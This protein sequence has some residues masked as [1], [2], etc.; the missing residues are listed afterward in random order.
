MGFIEH[1]K[2]LIPALSGLAITVWNGDPQPL[3]EFETCFCFVPE[4]Q[5]LYTEK[6][7]LSFFQKK[8]GGHIYAL[9]DALDTKILVVKID[10]QWIILGPY[11]ISEWQETSAKVL[12]AGYGLGDAFCLPY[13]LYRSKLP[14]LEQGYVIRIAT[15]LLTH[16]A[17]C[18]PPLE[19]ENIYLGP[20]A[21]TETRAHIAEQ[22]DAVELINRRYFTENQLIEAIAQGK[23]AEALQLNREM[24]LLSKGL[25]FASDAMQDHIAGAA[26]LR[27]LV[28]RAALQAGLTPVLIDALSQEY[29]QKM[30]CAVDKHQLRELIEEYIAAFCHMI[31]TNNKSNYSIYVK[32]AVQYI[33]IHLSESIP[34]DT[35][36][37]LNNISRTHFVH[38]FG[39]ETGKTIKQY[40][41][42]AR[43]ERAAE[44]LENSQLHIQEISS[45]VGYEDNNYFSKIF[46]SIMGVSPQEYRKRKTF[47]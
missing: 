18:I 41:A 15:L 30:H 32:R 4:F 36:C 2:I 6:G 9:T 34:A 11:V 13:K 14:L 38:L 21:G 1:S 39:K 45:Y 33:D 42:A 28:R 7:F 44:L 19:L 25:R 47:Y 37:A 22:Y 24:Y 3:K 43:C 40:I 46:K 23:T 20:T 12:L 35:L 5:G 27:V 17:G 10:A 31:R 8:D 16:T 29:A 26:I